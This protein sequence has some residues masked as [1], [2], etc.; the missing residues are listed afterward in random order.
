MSQRPEDITH[1]LATLGIGGDLVPAARGKN[2]WLTTDG[3]QLST[4]FLFTRGAL[5]QDGMR[6]A[7]RCARE[8]LGAA[9][10]AETGIASSL[11]DALVRVPSLTY[12]SGPALTIRQPSRKGVLPK[13]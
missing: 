13:V 5:R 11:L 1:L 7:D 8:E 10:D 12:T 6:N 4:I 9:V 2:G 3:K